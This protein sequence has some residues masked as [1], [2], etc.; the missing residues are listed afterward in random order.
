[1]LSKRHS[2]DLAREGYTVISGLVP[3]NLLR[4]ARDVITNFVQAELDRPE[5]WYR[6]KPLEWSIVPVHQAQAFWDIR[7]WPAVHRAFADLQG[8]E[9]LWVSMDRAV[10]KVPLSKKHPAHVDESVLH[11]DGDPRRPAT[12]AYQGMLFLTDV[13]RGEGSFECVP[14]IF[15]NL[16]QYFLAHPG[17]A[18]DAPVHTAGHE[19]VQVPARAGDLVVWSS[20][21]PHH[22]GHNRGHQPRLSMALAMRPEGTDAQRADRVE[23]WQQRR[24]PRWWR[25]W[26]GQIDP[27]P[28]PCATLTPLGRRLLGVDRWP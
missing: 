15:R 9:R 3:D 20:R 1:M 7:Q 4:P 5:T 12:W 19:V 28:G 11:W 26:R 13:G 14:S 21:L 22:G 27:E 6:H 23:C 2:E 18:V 8:T 17:P 16:E 25:G 10:F 24:A